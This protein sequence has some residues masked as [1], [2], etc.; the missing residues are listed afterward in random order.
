[1]VC[2]MVLTKSATVRR[3][4]SNRRIVRAGMKN[5]HG[6]VKSVLSFKREN[7]GTAN[8]ARLIYA[9]LVQQQTKLATC[10]TMQG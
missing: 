2:V 5:I 1:M 10:L 3:N 6:Y 7:D 4:L 9:R 8:S